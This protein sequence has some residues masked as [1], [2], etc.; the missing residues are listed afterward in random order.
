MSEPIQKFWPMPESSPRK[1]QT[2]V[3]KWMETLPSHIRYVL[4]EAPVGCHLKDTKILMFDGSLKKIQDIE[5]HDQ[6]MGIDSTKRIVKE[7]HSGTE[8]MYK[9]T[10]IKGDSFVV[11]ENHILSLITTDSGK[12]EKLMNGLNVINISVKEYLTKS[13]WFKENTKLYR[14]SYIEFTDSQQDLPI[15]PYLLGLLLGDGTIKSGVCITTIDEQI[16]EKIYYYANQLSLNIRIKAKVCTEANSYYFTTNIK[17]GKNDKNIL[18]NKLKELNI[19]GTTSGNKFIPH[20]YKVS[21]K[22]NRLSILAGLIDTDGY[23]GN[24]VFEYCT[25]SKTLCNDVKFICRS[26][27]LSATSSI[28]LINNIEYHRVCISGD[29]SD[30]PVILDRKKASI[31]K[32]KKRVTVTGFSIEQFGVD[33]YFGFECDGDNLYMLEDFTITH[34]SGK[35][36]IGVN[37]SGFLDQVKG[38]AYLL[39]PQKILQK[40]Y[41][42]TFSPNILSSLYGKSNYTCKS[43]NT[44]CDIGSDLKPKCNDCPHKAALNAAN[45]SPNCVLNYTLALLLFKYV[46]SEK[47]IPK[48]KLIVFDECH[49]LENHLTEFN[50]IQVGERR[51]KQ[52]N[53]KWKEFDT[54]S[55]AF[56]W[57]NDTYI[58]AVRELNSKIL[59]QVDIILTETE[60]DRVLTKDDI[61][62]I[63]KSRDIVRHMKELTEFV[64]NGL[65]QIEERYVFVPDK[66][67]FKYKE[68]YGKHVFKELVEPMADRF[69]FMSSTILDK[70]AYCSDL[71]IDPAK[72]AFISMPSEFPVENRP[73]I[74]MPK[75]KMTYGW[76]NP[77]KKDERTGM[78]QAIIDLLQHHEDD[79]GIIHTGSFQIADWLI[80]N[81]KGKIP[82]T[83]YEHGPKSDFTRDQVINDFQNNSG[84]RKLLI[85]PSITEGLDLKDDLGRFAIWAKVPFPFLGDNWVKRRQQLSSDWYSRQAMIAMIQGGGRIVRSKDDWG[86]VYILDESFGNLLKYSKRFL[87][88]WFTES[89]EVIK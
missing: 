65:D 38:N 50:A 55:K 28:K 54:S 63:N 74:Y 24:N 83:I 33:N 26:L 4:V 89:I 35:S 58:P 81:I 76:N 82:H 72:T 19:Y 61:E 5:V 21:S 43:K 25:K 86:H 69:L 48:R 34:N 10:P 56:K 40:Q 39:T 87:P 16:R 3:L 64:L 23:L 79:N 46:A 45:Y 49:T 17:G 80:Q 8:M 22:Q 67:F 18:I 30:I 66:H 53:V 88:K 52:F 42:D 37:Y 12:N 41:E 36:L 7:L 31:R 9:I 71:G 70:D 47:M 32:Q 75:M 14:P 51:C 73:I 77:D 13:N 11:N 27:G 2:E 62:L 6:L 29:I 84:E 1:T 57:L 59:K 15:D 68:I 44:N 78:V 20:Q 60:F 85:S